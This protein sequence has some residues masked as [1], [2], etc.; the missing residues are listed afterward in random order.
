MKFRQTGRK[1]ELAKGV[2]ISILLII[3]PFLFYFYTFAPNDSK[4]WDTFFGSIQSGAFRSVQI[5]LHAL[6][7]KITFIVITGTW[8]LTTKHWWKYAILV[9]FTM[10]LFQISGILNYQMQYIDEY[11]FWY[12]LPFI[13]PIV[14]FIILISYILSKKTSSNN[15]LDEDAHDFV[16][17][18]LSDKL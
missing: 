3:T 1:K 6:F 14:V 13:I 10:F 17:N 15:S 2:F 11:D 18:M 9:P 12:S 8:F 7:T 5:Y 4:Q 16:K